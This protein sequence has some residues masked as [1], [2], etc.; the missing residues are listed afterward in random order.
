[1]LYNSNMHD[2]LF[3][4]II[5]GEIP[6][7]VVDENDSVIV[8]LSLQ[9]HP[10]IVPKKHIETIFEMDDVTGTEIMKETIK[11]AKA[12]KNGL[13]ADGVNLLQNNGP[14]A[15]QEVMHFHLH[16]KPRFI[17]DEVKIHFPQKNSSEE[18]KNQVVKDIKSAL[19]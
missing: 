16:I 9:N 7:K 19:I 17:N 12:V 2:C 3:C 6:A 13:H 11:I 4:K 5:K 14:A 1:M 15:N 18:E 8:F 10:L